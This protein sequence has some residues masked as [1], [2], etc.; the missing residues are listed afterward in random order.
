VINRTG[1]IKLVRLGILHLW[2]LASNQW[3]Q[4]EQYQGS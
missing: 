3:K 1:L 4:N 2:I